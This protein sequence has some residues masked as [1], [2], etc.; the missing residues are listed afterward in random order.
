MKIMRVAFFL[1]SLAGGGAERM[2]LNLIRGL[3]AFPVQIDLLTAT[4]NGE[5]VSQIPQGINVVDLHQGRVFSSLFPLIRFLRKNH[6]DIL[7]S[8]V[9]NANLIA[10]LAGLLSGTQT[11]RVISVH[12]VGT[13]FRKIH[14]GVREKILLLGTRL[15]FRY[16]HQIVAVSRGVAEDLIRDVKLNPSLVT[17]IANPILSTQKLEELRISPQVKKEGEV[18]IVSAGRLVKEK[19]FFTLLTA[20]S[21]IHQRISSQLTIF[22]E[23][24][25]RAQLERYRD[26][27]GLTKVV[28][29]PG[30]Y[31]DI[32]QSMASATL[33]VVSS[34]T[35]GFG[36]VIVEALACGV[37]V[38][39]TDCP[40]GPREILQEGKYGRLV[41]M[42]Q[43]EKMAEAILASAAQ[44]T[45]CSFLQDRAGDFTFE[46]IASVYYDL[47]TALLNGD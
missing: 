4:L 19:D 11:K 24:P 29:F 47:F 38:V 20:F 15:F 25:E 8:A 33:C 35:E 42:Q 31:A 18:R 37:P 45:D 12:Q 43:P 44:K 22:G 6:P 26:E 2:V 9:D 23:G 34:L 41:E 27:L 17:T 5:L 7:F 46:K 10:I 13:K 36:N 14:H 32:F 3:Q 16:A 39:A 28:N 1:P 21:I 40:S 30:F